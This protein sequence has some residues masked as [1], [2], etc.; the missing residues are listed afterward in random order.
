MLNNLQKFK[1][2][3]STINCLPLNKG[4]V[5]HSKFASP[6]EASV[7]NECSSDKQLPNDSIQ[8]R[9][10]AHISCGFKLL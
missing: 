6:V 10:G 8:R 4:A 7:A 9:S 5:S 1:Y 2:R 3:G